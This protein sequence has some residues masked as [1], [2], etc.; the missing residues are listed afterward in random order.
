MNTPFRT[1]ADDDMLNNAQFDPVFDQDGN[2]VDIVHLEITT[3]RSRGI[4][5]MEELA[6]STAPGDECV[7]ADGWTGKWK[8][9]LN[10]PAPGAAHTIK[11]TK[12]WNSQDG[13]FQ[14]SATL[15]V[16]FEVVWSL[17]TRLFFGRYSIEVKDITF[18]TEDVLDSAA[19]RARNL[20]GRIFYA[21]AQ[22]AITLHLENGHNRTFTGVGV[23]YDAVK[24]EMTGN[25]YAIN[26]A[27]RM[28]EKGAVSD[29][30]REALASMGRVFNRAFEDGAQALRDIEAK[31]LDR[32]QKNATPRPVRA[33]VPAPRRNEAAARPEEERVPIDTTPEDYIPMDAYDHNV[34]EDDGVPVATE[35]NTEVKAD[36]TEADA[37]TQTTDTTAGLGYV[38]LIDGKQVA[39]ESA[40]ELFDAVF[41]A[42][43]SIGGGEEAKALLE[44]NRATLLRAEHDQEAEGVTYADLEAMIDTEGE[45][46]KDEVLDG[47]E[48]EIDDAELDANRI[49]PRKEGG[50]DIL[51]AYKAAFEKAN[52][53]VDAILMANTAWAKRLTKR[54]ALELATMAAA[55]KSKR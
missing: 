19:E 39:F 24:S 29:A 2:L 7:H 36:Q 54:Q 22:V 12:R 1:A 11:R 13:E 25:V 37:A 40:K 9:V 49:T 45:A 26:S 46:P 23:S 5:A 43:D 41:E 4:R 42:M 48:T 20:P 47:A 32:M 31:L 55:T 30:K 6:A 14:P 50:E 44:A 10:T 33:V 18:D 15:I 51:K 53:N 3:D 21:R 16:P 17:F 34:P 52:A 8:R 38:A 35:V 28:A 27:R